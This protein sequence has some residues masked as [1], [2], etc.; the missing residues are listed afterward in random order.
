VHIL[1][2]PKKFWK[3]S[4][5]LYNSQNFKNTTLSSSAWFSRIY[6]NLWNCNVSSVHGGL[7]PLFHSNREIILNFPTWKSN[8]SSVSFL[9]T[10]LRCE[11]RKIHTTHSYKM[12][13][14]FINIIICPIIYNDPLINGII[15]LQKL[16][17]FSFFSHASCR[18]RSIKCSYIRTMRT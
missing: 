5:Q 13:T 16:Q 14:L 9:L 8:Y 6:I 11:R 3:K 10:H 7:H 17:K 2:R 18:E 4:S 1:K 15:Y 12:L